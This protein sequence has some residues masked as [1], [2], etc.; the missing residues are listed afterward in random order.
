MF[1]LLLF[2]FIS[3]SFSSSGPPASFANLAFLSPFSPYLFA[4]FLAA[5]FLSFVFLF[6]FCSSLNFLSSASFCFL[7]ASNLG[8][9]LD[10]DI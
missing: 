2:L 6:V 9:I 3:G 5:K 1:L 8:L 7:A 4:S 10:L